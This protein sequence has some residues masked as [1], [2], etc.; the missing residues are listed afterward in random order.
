M[1]DY[2][3]QLHRE[4]TLS[5]KMEQ[6]RQAAAR[7]AKSAAKGAAV[8][9]LAGLLTVIDGEIT[10]PDA[11]NAKENANTVFGAA[12]AGGFIAMGIEGRSKEEKEQVYRA[13][14]GMARE[15]VRRDEG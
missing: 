6:W 3:E 15:Y 1:H 8:G 10:D 9:T 13:V 4:G 14:L 2:I 12:L 5:Y 11:S 7:Y